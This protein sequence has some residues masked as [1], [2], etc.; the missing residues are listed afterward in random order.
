MDTHGLGRW[1]YITITGKNGRRVLVTTVSQTCKTRIAVAG[2]K[3]ACAQQWHLLRQQGD[4]QPDPGKRFHQDLDKFLQPHMA[5]G[6]ELILLGDF[7]ETLGGS[8]HGL[9]ALI[10]KYALLDLL[11]YHHGIDGEVETYARGSLQATGLC[12]RH[13]DSCGINS[14]YW[15]HSVQ[16]L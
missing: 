12:I 14:M 4:P 10:N 5:A 8:F 7:N 11:P 9:D 15:V 3:T 13:P 16:L 6:K 1:S 2:A